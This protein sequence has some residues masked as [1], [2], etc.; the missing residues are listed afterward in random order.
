MMKI[1]L[2]IFTLVILILGASFT[3]LNAEPV[4]VNYYF[5]T[6]EVALSVVLVGTLV[7]GALIGV[8]AT[9]GKL[10]CLKLQLSRL[11]RS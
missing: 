8:S 7:V 4:Q 6:A 9:M 1:F 3:L 11:R 2:F 5:G 10:L